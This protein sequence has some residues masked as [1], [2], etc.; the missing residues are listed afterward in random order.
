[1][2]AQG[3]D[4]SL[5][6]ETGWVTLTEHP[7]KLRSVQMAAV[8]PSAGQQLVKIGQDEVS[9]SDIWVMER[10]GW[11]PFNPRESAAA[12]R[13]QQ[14][15]WK[16]L[17]EAKRSVMWLQVSASHRRYPFP[18]S[19][20]SVDKSS[21]LGRLSGVE[22]DFY[23]RGGNNIVDA[24]GCA[25]LKERK[26]KDTAE[27]FPKRLRWSEQTNLCCITSTPDDP[28][29]IQKAFSLRSIAAGASSA[30]DWRQTWVTLKLV[31]DPFLETGK[32]ESHLARTG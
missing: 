22:I 16:F 3:R 1:M 24:K 13:K 6:M 18:Y 2:E 28:P 8:T 5:K 14:L 4:R 27:W 11:Q 10:A 30:S 31:L 25:W 23:G 9:D 21:I 32:G 26:K 19:C 20:C 12:T 17:E 29:G 7:K 15:K